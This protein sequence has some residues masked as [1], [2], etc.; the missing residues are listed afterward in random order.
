MPK[1]FIIRGL[2]VIIASFTLINSIIS[3]R[4]NSWGSEKNA[5]KMELNF[6]F[7]QV[8]FFGYVKFILNVCLPDVERVIER[9]DLYLV[10]FI[11]SSLQYTYLNYLSRSLSSFFHEIFTHL[12]TLRN[13]GITNRWERVYNSIP[14][15]GKF[16]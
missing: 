4:L 7:F 12:F 6:I 9:I 14:H 16:Y 13:L 8:E 1:L 5:T 3:P 2:C 15:G 10:L 11:L